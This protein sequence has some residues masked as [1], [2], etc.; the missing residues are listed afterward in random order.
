MTTEQRVQQLTAELNRFIQIVVEQMQPERIVVFGSYATGNVHEWSDLDIVVVVDTDL[1]FF[2]RLKQIY[3]QVEPQ[4]GMDI[5][6]YTPTEWEHLQ[7]S[8]MFVRE[9]IAKKGKV[10]YERGRSAMV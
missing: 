3:M 9:V 2:K 7:I 10:V 5:V 8:R 6:V 1:P 4:V